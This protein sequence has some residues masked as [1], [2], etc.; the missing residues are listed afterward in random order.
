MT[1]GRRPRSTE[2]TSSHTD[3]PCEASI[4]GCLPALSARL[5]VAPRRLCSAIA[6]ASP[7]H[8]FK[9]LEAK[10]SAGC[11]SAPPPARQGLS[12]NKPSRRVCTSI[13]PAGTSMT[14]PDLG[15]AM[16]VTS[17]PRDQSSFA[18]SLDPCTVRSLVIHDPAARGC[19]T[20]SPARST[21]A[22]ASWY[23]PPRTRSPSR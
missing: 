6:S 7:H 23:R 1:R 10:F 3:T 5:C 21:A 8:P 17:D 15:M 18:G 2:T 20:A 14:Y 16:R 11:R 4:A 13:H 22:T 9:F 12:I 19:P